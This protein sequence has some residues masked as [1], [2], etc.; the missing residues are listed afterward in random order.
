MTLSF[1]ASTLLTFA[2]IAPVMFV[3]SLLAIFEGK[4]PAS[5]ILAVVGILMVLSSLFVL[6]HAQKHLEKMPFRVSRVEVAD[7][8][9][10]GI[11]ILYLVPLLRTSFSDL[12]LLVL[13]PA[14]AILL[15]FSVTGYG[16][17]FNPLLNMLNWHFYKAS[18]EEGVSY[19]LIT[20]KHLY[21]VADSITVGQLTKYTVIDMERS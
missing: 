3:Y 11:L 9:N 16:Y 13:I 19:I 12:D 1:I 15:A 4:Y 10:L 17:H 2:A 6:Q 18:T 5:F 21:S 20:R 7:K 14:V 8:E